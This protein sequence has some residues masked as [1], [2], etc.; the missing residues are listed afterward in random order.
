MTLVFGLLSITITAILVLSS[1]YSLLTRKNGQDG[2]TGNKGKAQDEVKDFWQSF[3]L[4]D[5]S[6]NLI[7]AIV[8]G[9][10]NTGPIIGYMSN[11]QGRIVNSSTG[12]VR[13]LNPDEDQ[14]AGE[15][16][17]EKFIRTTFGKRV[18]GY[19]LIR[20]I[21]PLTIDRVVKKDTSKAN[22]SND[23]SKQ[24]DATFVRRYGLY[25]DI[26]RPTYHTDVDTKD[27]IR[28]SVNSY[29]VIEVT[30]AE[31]AFKIYPDSFLQ[32]IS[33]II[34]GFV[35]SKVI[36]MTWEEYKAKGVSGRKF[37]DSELVELNSLLKPLG[38]R[39]TQFT[40]SDPQLNKEIQRVMEIRATAEETAKAKIKE[41]EG[42]KG[43]LINEGEGKAWA[44]ERLAVAKK[45][46]FTELVDMYVANGFST[47]AA[48][49]KA[50]D[51]IAA[52]FNAEAI[53]NLKGTYVPG[54]IGLQLGIKETKND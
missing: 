31:P 4:V 32:T 34:S 25:G 18:Y 28:F 29:S 36:M 48:A 5:D 43:F 13:H 40:M 17:F 53:G 27:G 21:K 50:S 26:L 54:N 20:S 16:P 3:G 6:P 51:M 52:E 8:A 14:Y 19:P 46:R 30:N 24:L 49:Q 41:G 23:L 45:R 39:V 33:D 7:R 2:T 47:V 35:S 44:I 11:L 37:D 9:N 22:E 38:V 12:E 1:L 15:N 42:Q 10:E